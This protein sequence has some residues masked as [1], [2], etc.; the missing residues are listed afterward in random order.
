[1]VTFWK[2]QY[3]GQEQVRDGSTITSTKNTPQSLAKEIRKEKKKY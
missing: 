2:L 3:S 1:M